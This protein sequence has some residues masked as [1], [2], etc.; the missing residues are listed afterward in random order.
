MAGGC[1]EKLEQMTPTATPGPILL[2]D[3][4]VI[5]NALQKG[6]IQ[7]QQQWSRVMQ[8]FSTVRCALIIAG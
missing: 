8:N 5:I 2:V 7:I 1:V 3:H 4:L 6:E